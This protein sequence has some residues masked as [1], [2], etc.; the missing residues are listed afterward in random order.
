[1]LHPVVCD[2]RSVIGAVS[3]V[4][5][6]V[7]VLGPKTEQALILFNV[8]SYL[9][10]ESQTTGM[11]SVQSFCYHGGHAVCQRLTHVA[12][13]GTCWMHGRCFKTKHMLE[14]MFRLV[15]R[16]NTVLR[17]V[18]RKNFRHGVD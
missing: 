6:T 8:V 7:L 5:V 10:R 16:W 4:D 1:V 2:I 13:R 14:R 11:Q 3:P 15:P 12:A 17:A 18:D 9:L